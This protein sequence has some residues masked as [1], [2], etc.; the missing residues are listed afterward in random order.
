[1]VLSGSSPGRCS[2]RPRSS[3]RSSPG[4]TSAL[5]VFARIERRRSGC[6]PGLLDRSQVSALVLER[7]LRKVVQPTCQPPSRSAARR[8]RPACT[9]RRTGCRSS[10]PGPSTG[11]SPHHPRPAHERRRG[12]RGQ[13]ETGTDRQEAPRD[14]HA[15][16]AR[17]HTRSR[18]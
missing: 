18:R 16:P 6:A 17:A 15:Q 2:Q 9:R 5:I 10:S 1:V 4:R 14:A 8:R 12:K 11:R 13:A 7:G 3:A